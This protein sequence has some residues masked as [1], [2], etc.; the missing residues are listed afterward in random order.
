VKKESLQE[1]TLWRFL[2]QR[3]LLYERRTLWGSKREEACTS[4]PEEVV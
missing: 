1:S 4:S 2:Q 3:Y